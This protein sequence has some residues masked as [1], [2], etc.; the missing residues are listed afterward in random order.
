MTEKPKKPSKRTSGGAKKRPS[1]QLAVPLG[2]GA[3]EFL[4]EVDRK[5]LEALAR[6]ER[7]PIAALI[8]GPAPDSRTKVAQA[9]QLVR[10]TLVRNGHLAQF[11]EELVD[12]VSSHSIQAQQLAQVEAYDVVFSIPDSVGSI[13]EIHD[14]SKT[15]WLSHKIVTFLDKRWNDGY[16]N[17]SLI[18]IQSVA[19]CSIV[20]YDKNE[21]PSCIVGS[22]LETIRRLQEIYYFLGRRF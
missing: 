18:E 2:I 10:D 13:A 12:P 21:L 5:R 3:K 1:R 17:R 7:V 4:Q 6:I 15:P 11:S 9:R 19:T 20:L 8:W 14:F 22:C 16:A